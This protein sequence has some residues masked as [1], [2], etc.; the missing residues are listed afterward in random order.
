VTGDTHQP[1]G[2]FDSGVGGLSVLRA[3]Q[4]ELPHERLIYVADSAYV[5]YGEKSRDFVVRRAQALTQFLVDEGAKA[6]VVACNTATAAA[7]VDLRAHFNL[8]I[9]GIEPALKPAVAVTHTG[10][11]AVLATAGTLQ[12]EAFAELVAR[13]GQ[14]VRVCTQA[15]P[16]LVERVEAC[17]LDSALT[18]ALVA[19]YTAPLL[20]AGADTLVLGCTHYPFLMPAVTAFAGPDVTVL[21]TGGPVARHLHHVLADRKLLAPADGAG[22]VQFWTS[23]DIEGALKVVSGLWGQPVTIGQLPVAYM[24]SA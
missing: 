7:V 6:V 22:A 2:V 23:G 1:I 12:S 20:A 10:V 4:A 9:I 21:E 16:G 13:Y 24:A 11:V 19:Q 14:H 15:C 18:R 3:I 8:P 5:P 17:D